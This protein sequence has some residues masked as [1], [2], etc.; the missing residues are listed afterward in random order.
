MNMSNEMAPVH[1]GE[2]LREELSE[3]GMSARALAQA[4]KVP[5]NR[6]TAILNGERGVTADT[7][8]RLG[9]YFGTSTEFWMNLQ[10]D[11]EIR[12]A[13]SDDTSGILYEIV[14]RQ[15]VLLRDAINDIN[16]ERN[17]TPELLETMNTISS[18][19][20]LC[21]QLQKFERSAQV[22]ES[23]KAWLHAFVGPL[24][25]IHEEGVFGTKLSEHLPN[26]LDSFRSYTKQFRSPSDFDLQR[27]EE[28]F[29][30]NADMAINPPLPSF[31]HLDCAWLNELDE[32]SSV[33]R[34]LNLQFI[35]NT[36]L[37]CDAFSSLCSDSLR[38]LLGDWR[39]QIAWPNAIWENL[40][41]RVRFYKV[42]GFDCNLTNVPSPVFQ[43]ILEI[44][45]IRSNPPDLIDKY[46]PIFHPS[47]NPDDGLALTRT[48]KAH[49]WLQRFESHL[50]QF[51]DREMTGTFGT[52]WVNQQLPKATAEKWHSRKETAMKTGAP[53]RP[54]V[55][56]AEFT[57]YYTIL[58]Q[59]DRWDRVFQR[60]FESRE[61]VRESFQRLYPI[62][63]DTM[64]KRPITQDD[65]LLLYVETKR[66]MKTVDDTHQSDT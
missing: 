47:K 22:G 48:N 21:T 57:D 52:S 41:A 3:L 46:D 53:T 8:R 55:S 36:L 58:C 13:E 6:I 45:E 43:E 16:A 9:R 32:L 1:P 60:L 20:T 29:T 38:K 23:T 42:L 26:T 49:D 15:T 27:L 12:Q 62:R 65:E 14:P 34:L 7:A 33:Q 63:N 30:S 44:T 24:D 66:L 17:F 54:L 37:K 61:S 19:L 35:G 31:K 4:I 50:R 11:Y 56:Y 39:D 25:E 2:V 64:H 10:K 5:V 59:E 28:E 51:I 40:D 18:N